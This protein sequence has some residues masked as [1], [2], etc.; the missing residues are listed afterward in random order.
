MEENKIIIGEK[1]GIISILDTGT[2][3]IETRIL[4]NKEKI[5]DIYSFI[6][7]KNNYMICGDG[8]GNII[9]FEKLDELKFESKKGHMFDVSILALGK[10][11]QLFTCSRKTIKIWNY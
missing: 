6:L 9:C 5:G 4:V 1:H 7:L 8:E 10:D 11:H 2:L 3:Q